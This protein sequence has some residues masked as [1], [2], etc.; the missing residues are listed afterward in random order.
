MAPVAAINENLQNL[1]EIPVL[2]YAGMSL[3]YS[4]KIYDR[5]FLLLAWG[6]TGFRIIHSIIHC[7]YNNVNHRFG[8]Y[9]LSFACLIAI[10][11]KII[12]HLWKEKID[13]SYI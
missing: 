10:W 6:F 9:L 3:V 8:A 11:V 2:Y 1:F 7:T 12:L 5:N 4:M 13:I